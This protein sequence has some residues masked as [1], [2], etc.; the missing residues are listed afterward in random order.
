MLDQQEASLYVVIVSFKKNS[1]NS[2]WAW[3]EGKLK[4]EKEGLEC[5]F[6]SKFGDWLLFK[7]RYFITI[8]ILL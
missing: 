2:Q 7:L 1:K 8:I 6:I 4:F 5:H 3:L